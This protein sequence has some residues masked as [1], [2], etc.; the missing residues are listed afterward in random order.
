MDWCT[1][2]YKNV[3]IKF[4]L[5]QMEYIFNI[6]Y[7]LLFLIFIHVKNL[8]QYKTVN[9]K[10]N[11][12]IDAI[13]I[14]FTTIYS[15]L[16]NN[17]KNRLYSLVDMLVKANIVDG[18]I[19]LLNNY[20][21]E[22]Y[23]IDAYISYYAG[24]YN[25]TEVLTL[26]KASY[27]K[28]SIIRGA[29]KGGNL[30]LIKTIYNDENGNISLYPAVVISI[31]SLNFKVADELL[32][33]TTFTHSEINEFAVKAAGTGN[34]DFVKYLF[35]T[36]H[37]SDIT[38]VAVVAA[39]KKYDEIRLWA[40]NHGAN[41][42]DIAVAA[43][44]KA[45]DIATLN[46]AYSV[47]FVEPNDIAYAAATIGNLDVLIDSLNRGA[48]INYYMIMRRAVVYQNLTFVRTLVDLGANDFQTM[49]DYAALQGKLDILNY[50]LEMGGI[51]ISYF[52]IVKN[53]VI[54]GNLDLVRNILTNHNIH[55]IRK[56]ANEAAGFGHVHILEY[57]ISLGAEDYDSMLKK[58]VKYNHFNVVKY[59][60][61]NQLYTKFNK[62][63]K[64]ALEN[65]N[66]KILIYALRRG[67]NNYD[68]LGELALKL[69]NKSAY[70]IINIFS[71]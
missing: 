10:M 66:I 41:L 45:N 64:I 68:F 23:Y 19:F 13:F 53:A 37:A 43:I 26:G 57:L 46:W 35:E 60:V 3:R 12:L 61:E 32:K 18:L 54:N 36:Y 34:I 5:Q 30:N 7:D 71:Q 59:L 28:E 25:N 24:F 52:Q 47:G 56:L 29:A 50:A 33:L 62:L 1:N 58:A 4:L 51:G 67:A 38:R 70:N 20:N 16:V 55:N 8:S 48:D 49:A 42:N 69:K 44:E 40:Y 65:S 17:W 2:N 21:N 27:F 14:Y 22:Y 15:K 63:A 11:E 6:P 39:S 31:E 9:K